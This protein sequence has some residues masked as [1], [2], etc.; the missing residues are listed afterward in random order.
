MPKE[1][2]KSDIKEIVERFGRA[3]EYA[4]EGGF[5]GIEI[6]SCTSY[7][8]EQFLSPLYN[9]RKDEYGGSLENRT[10]LLLEV[11]DRVYK[12]TAGEI[13]LGIRIPGDELVPGGLTLEDMKG[14]ARTLEATGKIDFLDIKAGSFNQGVGS[15]CPTYVED[16]WMVKLGLPGGIKKVLNQTRVFAVG[17]IRHPPLAEKILADGEADM[18]ALARTLVADPE[19]ANKASQGRFEDIIPCISCNQ[20]CSEHLQR[21]HIPI[22]CV[23]NPATGKEKDWGIGTLEPA[24]VSKKVVVIGGG[25]AGMSVAG[26]AALRGHKVILYERNKLGGQLN[27]AARLP[28][29]EQFGEAVSWF[30]GQLAKSGVEVREGV[31]ATHEIVS[32]QN[33]D[34]VVVATGAKANRGGFSPIRTDIPE[35]PGYQQENVFAA[36]DLLSEDCNVGQEVVIYD[37]QGDYLS[38][39]VADMLLKQGKSVVIIT[40]YHYAGINGESTTVES[41]YARILGKKVSFIPNAIV[42]KINGSTV[43]FYDKFT[44]DEKTMNADSVIL[45][46]WKQP[47]K[48]LYNTLNGKVKKLIAIGDCVSPR[49]LEQAVYEAHQTARGI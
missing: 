26:L 19:W 23:L 12:E 2:E 45:V 17:K 42:T 8:L 27:L 31:E 28:G 18:V 49:L 11:I 1:M 36:E 47:N 48:E 25:P 38:L 13:A 7:L 6:H 41:L 21:F 22:T 35:L 10:R 46:T 20:G 34:V 14:I 30:I 4:K 33:P 37:T 44:Q 15:T 5:D 40:H 29:R 24:K 3:A 43:W 9:L 39:A 32:T 16:G